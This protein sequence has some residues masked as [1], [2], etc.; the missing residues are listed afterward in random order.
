MIFADSVKAYRMPKDMIWWVLG[1]KG[2]R[3]V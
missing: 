3:K 1:R 2:V